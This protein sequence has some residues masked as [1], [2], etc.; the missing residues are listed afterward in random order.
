[1]PPLQPIISLP[2][3]AQ[4]AWSIPTPGR[5]RWAGLVAGAISLSRPAGS[6]GGRSRHGSTPPVL[7]GLVRLGMLD[8][9]RG[10]GAGTPLLPARIQFRWFGVDLRAAA[11]GRP[12]P[13]LAGPADFARVGGPAATG[14]TGRQASAR[15][16]TFGRHGG[17]GRP[18]WNAIG[19][20]PAVECA[21]VRLALDLGVV[22]SQRRCRSKSTMRSAVKCGLVTVPSCRRWP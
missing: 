11:C 18:G 16:A 8:D 12:I 6:L 15:G 21:R 3:P 5:Q 7:A 20:E 9:E 1:M 19:R 13:V 14:H 17:A 10:G 2:L 22:E 4:E